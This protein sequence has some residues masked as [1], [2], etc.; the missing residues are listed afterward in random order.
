M[1]GT[2]ADRFSRKN[3]IVYSDLIQA[4]LV[5]SLAGLMFFLMYATGAMANSNLPD[6]LAWL[7][8]LQ[9]SPQGNTITI[10][11]M[12]IVASL[13][14]IVYA[15]FTPAITAAIPDLV[16]KGKLDV[17]N[18]LNQFAIFMAMFLGQGLGGLLFTITGAPLLFLLNSATYFYATVSETFITVPPPAPRPEMKSG[19]AWKSFIADTREGL[20]YVWNQKGM[21]IMFLAAG[22]LH[23][24]IA[25]MVLLLPFYV[26]DYLK[27]SAAWYGYL[28]AGVG[29]GSVI[30]YTI[31]SMVNVRGRAQ[32]NLIILSLLG[33]ALSLG[34]IG[35]ITTP[36]LVLGIVVITGLAT[37]VFIV[38]TTTVI[39]LAA[40]TEIRGRVFGLL[41]TLTSGVAPIGMGIAGVIAD[42]ANKN[43]PVIYATCG[44][45]VLVMSIG[46]ALSREARAFL[47]LDVSHRAKT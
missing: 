39:Q 45:L 7:S 46:L 26:E 27:Q 2:F 41:T 31:A 30:G 11:W 23:L 1:A 8:F 34:V 14:A 44:L 10:V 6:Y 47:A 42:M 17:A 32:S 33:A 5:L 24:L 4:V 19:E 22:L 28:L 9:L 43:I 37:G 3:I 16:P 12:F 36:F 20:A 38:K 13:G 25:P 18:S 40:S 21:R 29:V 35:F 15:F